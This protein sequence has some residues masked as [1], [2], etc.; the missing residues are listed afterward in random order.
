LFWAN[1]CSN[2]WWFFHG[3]LRWMNVYSALRSMM[4]VG[5]YVINHRKMIWNDEWNYRMGVDSL[6]L[7]I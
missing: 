5:V 2:E 1:Y 4:S 3:V 6:V 7:S